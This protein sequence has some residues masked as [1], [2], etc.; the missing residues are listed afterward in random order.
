MSQI[1]HANDPI[2]ANVDSDD[3]KAELSFD[4][5]KGNFFRGIHADGV[6]GG[7]TP[8]GLMALTFYAERFA[9]PTQIT[10]KLNPDRTLGDEVAAARVVRN[11]IVREAEC[12]I[13]ME[14]RTA[15]ALVIFLSDQLAT[16]KKLTDGVKDSS[17]PSTI[18]E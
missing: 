2:V 16:F 9:I 10:H 11:N 18:K 6:W 12:C 4:L 5:I 17:A 13:Y 15:E 8:Q 1:Q 3:G 7:I 14:V